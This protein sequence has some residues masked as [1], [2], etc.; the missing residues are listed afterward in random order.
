MINE[1]IDQLLKSLRMQG[2]RAVVEQELARAQKAKSSYADFYARVLREQF[3]LQR[4]RSL[5]YRIDRAALPE[6]WALETF[7]FDAQPGVHAPTMHQLAELGFVAKKENLVFVGATGVGKTGLASAILLK[8]LENGYR[9]LFVKAQDLFDEMYAS[10]ADR[11][12]RKLIDRLMSVD[13]L[14]IDEMGYLNL[15]PEQTNLFFKLMEE[16]YSRRSTIITTNLDYGA[17]PKLLPHRTRLNG[18]VPLRA[19]LVLVDMQARHLLVRHRAAPRVDVGKELCSHSQA[20]RRGRVADGVQQDGDAGQRRAGPRLANL[21][22]EQMLDRIPLRGAGRVVTDGDLQPKRIR[23][24]DLELLLPAPGTV[25]VAAAAVGQD[26]EPGPGRVATATDLLPPAPDRRDREV[27]RI[28]GQA[29][30]DDAGV[31]TR[32][33]DAI[34]DGL[35][36]RVA[37]KVV[38]VHLGRDRAVDPARVLEAPNQLLLLGI[39][40]DHR[41]ACRI[42]L[43]PPRANVTELVV[44]RRMLAGREVLDVGPCVDVMA[45]QQAAHDAASYAEPATGQGSLQL[46]QAATDPQHA[47]RGIARDLVAHEMQQRRLKS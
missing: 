42:K 11:S 1:D 13:V 45:T 19:G 39:D 23:E 41:V 40:A 29:H 8:A 25:A 22:E 47:R 37:R 33:V 17:G 3:K 20:G 24:A 5:A 9:G 4:E 36:V 21:T 43:P 6:R 16:R 46:G 34:R 31:G 7:P 18:V 28:A 44:A 12:S 2:M 30:I 10:L 15:R 35:G 27:R 14:L 38:G 26:E 32:I